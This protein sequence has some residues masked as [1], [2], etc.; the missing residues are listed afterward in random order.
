MRWETES[1]TFTDGDDNV[2][3]E[4]RELQEIKWI[5]IKKTIL[6]SAVETLR[7]LGCYGHNSTNVDTAIELLRADM[8]ALE[9]KFQ[10]HFE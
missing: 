9:D 1:V 10:E 4:C 6:E 5:V 2:P 7:Y 8:E 3:V